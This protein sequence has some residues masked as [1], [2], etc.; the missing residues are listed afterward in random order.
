METGSA[1]MIRGVM[2]VDLLPDV[3][4][5]DLGLHSRDFYWNE[6]FLLCFYL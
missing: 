4:L 1:H 2:A 6:V 5:G 3:A